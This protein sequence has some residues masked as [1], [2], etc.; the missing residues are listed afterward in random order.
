M[1][2][3]DTIL[4][5]FHRPS[6]NSHPASS[7]GNQQVFDNG[8]QVGSLEYNYNVNTGRVDILLNNTKGNPIGK[9]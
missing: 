1:A 9:L 3:N 2:K 5:N 6:S 4:G 7:F 8:R